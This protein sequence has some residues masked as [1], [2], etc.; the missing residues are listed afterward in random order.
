[1]NIAGPPKRVI[2]KDFRP[3]IN[4]GYG[5]EQIIQMAVADEEGIPRQL[6]IRITLS[7][8][9][10]RLRRRL[11]RFPRD[12]PVMDDWPFALRVEGPVTRQHFLRLLKFEPRTHSAVRIA[13]YALHGVQITAQISLGGEAFR[14]MEPVEDFGVLVI[15]FKVF[16]LDSPL[17]LPAPGVEPLPDEVLPRYPVVSCER[18]GAKEVPLPVLFRFMV[19]P[20]PDGVDITW[21]ITR[22]ILKL[23]FADPRDGNAAF[24]WYF[25]PDPDLRRD[26]SFLN[27]DDLLHV[28]IFG[29]VNVQVTNPLLPD[30]G[31]DLPK[32]CRDVL[33]VFRARYENGFPGDAGS[34]SRFFVD[35]L[36]FEV[37]TQQ[38]IKGVKDLDRV[39]LQRDIAGARF[40]RL[41]EVK[42]IDRIRPAGARFEVGQD[43]AGEQFDEW[44]KGPPSVA[45]EIARAA[46]DISIGFIPVVGDAVDYAEFNHALATG[47]DRWGRKAADW[48]IAL[49]GLSTLPLLGTIFSI[50]RTGGK[51]TSSFLRFLG[52]VFSGPGAG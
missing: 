51:M 36:A 26:G 4:A 46:M 45:E 33:T 21:C 3:F 24:G 29:A 27:Y 17:Q 8:P 35:P 34:A 31:Y 50:A 5:G 32:G 28:R 39:A 6:K 22:Q 44:R 25:K 23:T 12:L 48:E 9:M 38:V 18:G 37:F 7:D 2:L 40:F 15:E 1:M 47:E 42:S 52:K 30:D 13:A 11:H 10:T 43:I 20:R 41:E 49:M 16:R 19:E 14:P